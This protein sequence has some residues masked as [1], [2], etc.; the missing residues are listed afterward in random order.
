MN[1]RMNDGGL[2]LPLHTDL[3]ASRST[4]GRNNRLHDDSPRDVDSS[5]PIS[6]TG[7]AALLTDKSGLTLAIGFG[8][9]SAHM[10]RSR[11]IA[12][13]DRVQR[14]SCKS[15]LIGEE[16]TELSKGPGSMAI[17]LRTSNRAIGACPNVP[18][19]FNR[20][21]LMVLFGF[22]HNPF[23]DDMIRI[24]V[25][26]RLFARELFE[27]AFRTLGATLLQALPQSVVSLAG[28]LNSL[29]TKGFAFRVCRKV[30]N[31]QINPKSSS[32]VIGHRF[33]HIKGHSQIEHATMQD[34]ISLPFDAL[35]PG[36]LIGSHAV[37]NQDTARKSQERHLTNA[38]EGHHAGVIDDSPF[39]LEGR[40]DTLIT[41]VG[42][43]G[44][45]NTPD[46]QLSRQLVGGTQVAIDHLLQFKLV[47]GF[48]HE[49][50]VCHV[51]CPRIER[52]HGFKQGVMVF[53]RWCQFQ[54]HRLFHTDSIAEL[55]SSVSG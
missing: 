21:P 40:L 12:R 46:S 5:I 45:T 33:R 19:F 52:M 10:A 43:A 39:W 4:T 24:L 29:S 30:D 13:V 28:G 23:G 42:V 38:L 31:A 35:E 49:G 18:E 25:E 20:Y 47:G 48:V 17:A 26:P 8:T 51:V 55:R 6:V 22:V 27:M 7:I 11:R 14:D 50:N 36:L 3:I 34:H 9:V 37:G 16:R 32:H 53:W 54:V 2:S 1:P 44:F 41:L 15:G